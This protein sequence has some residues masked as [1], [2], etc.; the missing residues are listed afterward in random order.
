MGLA[1]TASV[2]TRQMRKKSSSIGLAR[3][4]GTWSILKTE[5]LHYPYPTTEWTEI[6]GSNAT[7]AK[8]KQ[9]WNWKSWIIDL[10]IW[11]NCA[12]CHA[13][14]LSWAA[15]WIASVS[16]SANYQRQWCTWNMHSCLLISRGIH[17]VLIFPPIARAWADKFKHEDGIRWSGKKATAQPGLRHQPPVQSQQNTVSKGTL[18]RGCAH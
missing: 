16:W 17:G 12:M 7:D 4:M 14:L 11:P 18:L 13:V 6:P 9:K 1:K 15:L 5:K 8:L 3:G 2:W 10:G